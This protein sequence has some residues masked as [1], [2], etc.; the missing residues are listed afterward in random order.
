MIPYTGCVGGEEGGGMSCTKVCN[1]FA[2]VYELHCMYLV[3]NSVACAGLGRGLHLKSNKHA[4]NKILWCGVPT[5]TT[6][7]LYSPICHP[8]PCFFRSEQCRVRG[9]SRCHRIHHSQDMSDRMEAVCAP[10]G[11]CHACMYTP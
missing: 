4:P 3:Y 2:R 10:T 8:L 6:T 9:Y 11:V 7:D 5:L 1:M